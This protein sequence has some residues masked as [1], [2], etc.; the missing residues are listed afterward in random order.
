[1]VEVSICGI[2]PFYYPGKAINHTCNGIHGAWEFFCKAI[3][4]PQFPVQGALLGHK[5]WKKI[6]KCKEYYRFEIELEKDKRQSWA[7]IQD[8]FLENG[9]KQVEILKSKGLPKNKIKFAICIKPNDKNAIELLESQ[10]F[11]KNPLFNDIELKSTNFLSGD[12][13][14]VKTEDFYLDTSTGIVY[15]GNNV[16]NN[17]VTLR[18]KG[19]LLLFLIPICAIVSIAY[20]IC[21]IAPAI[22]YI[23][24]HAIHTCFFQKGDQKIT[25]KAV[26]WDHT[27][28]GL[29]QIWMCVRNVIR[30]PFFIIG[31]YVGAIWEIMDPLNGMKMV[32]SFEYFWNHRVSKHDDNVMLLI[33]CCPTENFKMGWTDPKKLGTSVNYLVP[34]MSPEAIV[35]VDHEG[36]ILDDAVYYIPPDMTNFDITNC[37]KRFNITADAVH[38]VSRNI[39]SSCF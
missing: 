39:I 29:R 26:V 31:M 37:Q 35:S 38:D 16:G 22:I 27:K 10:R 13:C 23:I 4:I 21:R 30:T 11:K 3:D 8:Q 14:K 25:F 6:Y 19:F 32:G 5:H 9:A 36:N 33:M 1:M 20:N 18:I 17:C 7:T 12:V 28:D 34:C 2:K 24:G 15:S